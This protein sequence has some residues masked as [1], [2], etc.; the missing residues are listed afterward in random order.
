MT[1][2]DGAAG[3]SD[4]ALGH[5]LRSANGVE[6]R[7]IEHAA[8]APGHD[9]HDDRVDLFGGQRVARFVE[10]VDESTRHVSKPDQQQGDAHRA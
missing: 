5:T 8:V 7:S 1:E 9:P 2:G 10:Q 3:P 4:I 6:A